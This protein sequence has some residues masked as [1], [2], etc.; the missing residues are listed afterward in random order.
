MLADGTTTVYRSGTEYEA[1]FPVLNWT[2]LPGTTEVHTSG[3]QISP[4]AECHIINHHTTLSF[5]TI[6][7]RAGISSAKRCRYQTQL[8]FFY[9]LMIEFYR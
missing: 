6:L 1:I 3:P 2:T 9:Q 7:F 8:Q 5:L 4:L